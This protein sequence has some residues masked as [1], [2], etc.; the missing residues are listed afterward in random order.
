MPI[1]LTNPIFHNEDAAR[2][3]FEASVGRMATR[4]ARIA[5]L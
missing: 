3:H 4:F 2:A 5:A 1:D